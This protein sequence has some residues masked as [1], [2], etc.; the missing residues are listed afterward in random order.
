MNVKILITVLLGGFASGPAAAQLIRE[1]ILTLTQDMKCDAVALA[2][3]LAPPDFILNSPLGQS[4]GDVKL[5]AD[6]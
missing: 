6:F 2:D 4:D 3:A 5:F 1:A